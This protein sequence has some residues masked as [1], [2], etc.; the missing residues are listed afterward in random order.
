MTSL[1][2][3]REEAQLQCRRANELQKR[4]DDPSRI[5]LNES[6]LRAIENLKPGIGTSVEEIVRFIITDWI[7]DVMGV[8]W[9]KE[10]G[11]LK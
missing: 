8:A 9:M 2:E 5:E 11:L 10:K 7:Q 1:S 4:L 3:W 6:Q